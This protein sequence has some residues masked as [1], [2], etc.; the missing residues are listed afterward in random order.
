MKRSIGLSI[1]FTFLTCG[2]YGIYWFYKLTEETNE[3][4]EDYTISPGL[5]I[6]LSIITCGLYNLYWSYKMGQLIAIARTNRGQNS[7]DESILY[8]ILTLLGLW[9]I[10]YAILQSHINNMVGDYE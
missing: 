8:L 9:I 1:L 6:L 7:S 5:A 2:L 10:V 3:L 4:S